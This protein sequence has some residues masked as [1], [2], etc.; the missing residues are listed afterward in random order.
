MNQHL[1]QFTSTYAHLHVCT[2]VSLYPISRSPTLHS[3]HSSD[4]HI[5][6]GHEDEGSGMG[7]FDL[8]QSLEMASRSV[9]GA[10]EEGGG[11][12]KRAKSKDHKCIW[13]DEDD[14]GRVFVCSNERYVHPTR[15]VQDAYGAEHPDILKTCAFHAEDCCGN[16]PDRRVKVKFPNDLA[17]CNECFVQKFKKQPPSRTTFQVPGVHEESIVKIAKHKDT[18]PKFIKEELTE[19]TTC[20]WVPKKDNYRDRGYVGTPLG[21]CYGPT[22]IHTLRHPPHATHSPSTAHGPPPPCTI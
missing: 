17:F 11:G 8:A 14:M 16:H 1:L 2:S 15:K 20:K 18:G 19:E 5:R 7:N 21:H 9:G 13:R 3:P 12:N 6:N 10:D 22:A 4:G